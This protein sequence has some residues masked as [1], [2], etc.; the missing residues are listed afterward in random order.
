MLLFKCLLSITQVHAQQTRG[1][2]CF[3]LNMVESHIRPAPQKT[4]TAHIGAIQKRTRVIGECATCQHAQVGIANIEL[5][6]GI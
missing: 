6:L 2:V 4:I 1:N 3:H 5:S